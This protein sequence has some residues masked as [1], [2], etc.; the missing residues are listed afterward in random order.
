[1]NMGAERACPRTSQCQGSFPPKKLK[2]LLRL[3]G[4][5]KAQEQGLSHKC[6]WCAMAWQVVPDY[7]L[8]SKPLLISVLWRWTQDPVGNFVLPTAPYWPLV[9]GGARETWGKP[10]EKR[11]IGSPVPA[12]ALV[13]AH[14]WPAASDSRVWFLPPSHI[15][16]MASLHRHQHQWPSPSPNS[17]YHPPWNPLLK[18]RTGAEPCNGAFSGVSITGPSSEPLVFRGPSLFLL[19]YSP[20]L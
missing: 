6:L 12:D 13:T 17:R 19:F 4:Q 2:E 1:M 9:I 7:C 18:L 5:A 15:R 16:L 8:C 11:G 10:E 14:L 3:H 20:G